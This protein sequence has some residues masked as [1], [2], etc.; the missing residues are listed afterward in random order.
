MIN[1]K[2]SPDWIDLRMKG[3]EG[4]EMQQPQGNAQLAQARQ[5]MLANRPSAEPMMEEDMMMEE[6]LPAGSEEMMLAERA[7]QQRS[8]PIAPIMQVLPDWFKAPNDPK[9]LGIFSQSAVAAL[10]ENG[11]DDKSIAQFNP[12]RIQPSDPIVQFLVQ[13]AQG[14]MEQQQ[15]MQEPQQMRRGGNMHYTYPEDYKSGIRKQ[16]GSMH[17]LK[18]GQY[19]RFQQG[20]NMYEGMVKYYDPITG[21]FELDE[22]Y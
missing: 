16:G 21:N 7:N 2:T 8:N 11:F 5:Q 10:R 15:Q 17:N 20:G 13:E 12:T 14:M 3:Q 19:V 4:M 1:T 9:G 6:E 22:N 18:R